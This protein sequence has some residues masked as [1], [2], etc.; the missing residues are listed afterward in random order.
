[1]A[2]FHQD[3]AEQIIR[4]VQYCNDSTGG[5]LEALR[6]LAYKAV[7]PQM[8]A[9]FLAAAAV[10]SRTRV[11]GLLAETV[12]SSRPELPGFLSCR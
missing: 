6:Q 9:S 11:S 8:L 5:D 10:D 4:Q 7:V 1:M 3:L 2:I 12:S